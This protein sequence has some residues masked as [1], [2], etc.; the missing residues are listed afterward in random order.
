MRVRAS[1]RLT[2]T[3]HIRP[4]PDLS[5]RATYRIVYPLDERPYFEVGRAIHEIVDVSER[6][7]RCEVKTSDQPKEGELVAGRIS[8]RGSDPVVVTGQVIRARPG[9]VILAFEPPGVP[10]SNI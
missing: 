10:Y 5:R 3:S 8:F 9:L 6:G 4:V 7:L 1:C 2:S